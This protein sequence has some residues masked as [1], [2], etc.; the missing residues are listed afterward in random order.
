MHLSEEYSKYLDWTCYYQYMLTI[1]QNSNPKMSTDNPEWHHI[2]QSAFRLHCNMLDQV[3]LIEKHFAQ[4]SQLMSN[5]D[6]IPED[7]PLNYQS[8]QQTFN[9]Q[10]DGTDRQK[11][12]DKTNDIMDAIYPLGRNIR[13]LLKENTSDKNNGYYNVI[14]RNLYG[15]LEIR[16]NNLSLLVNIIENS[17]FLK[18]ATMKSQEQWIKNIEH[19]EKKTFKHKLFDRQM[20]I[21][22]NPDLPPQIRAN[23]E[24]DI[25]LA[26][27]NFFKH[28]CEFDIY[29]IYKDDS[30]QKIY[31]DD[32]TR[33]ALKAFFK[34]CNSFDVSCIYKDDLLPQIH[35]ENPDLHTLIQ[36]AT[37]RVNKCTNFSKLSAL[38]HKRLKDFK[39]DVADHKIIFDDLEGRD[40]IKMTNAILQLEVMR[41]LTD[42]A[43]QK[44]HQ[45]IQNGKS[46]KADHFID[47]LTKC[48]DNMFQVYA[49]INRFATIYGMNVEQLA[50]IKGVPYDP[51]I[52]QTLK[53]YSHNL[54]ILQQKFKLTAIDYTIANNHK[55]NNEVKLQ[56]IKQF[57]QEQQA[58]LIERTHTEL[59][60][61]LPSEAEQ[62]T[63]QLPQPNINLNYST[64]NAVV[65]NN[66][67]NYENNGSNG[68][69]YPSS[70]SVQSYT[71]VAQPVI[72]RNNHQETQQSNLPVPYFY[73]A[74]NTPSRSAQSY[75][76]VA[77]PV[78]FRN[79]HQELQQSSLPAPQFYH[80]NGNP[81]QS[82]QSSYPQQLNMQQPAIYGANY[83]K[84]QQSNLP[85]PYFYNTNNTPSQSA[86]P[87]ANIH[88]NP[89]AQ[90]YC[91]SQNAV[92][93]K[94]KMT[95]MRSHSVT[96][97]VVPHN[98]QADH[99]NYNNSASSTNPY[100]A[101]YF[102]SHASQYSNPTVQTN[103]SQNNVPIR[104]QITNRRSQ[105]AVNP[106]YPVATQ[107]SNIVQQNNQYNYRKI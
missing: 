37:T 94:P 67:Y 8:M 28:Y 56:I 35:T 68:N 14:L 89:T 93:P 27:K 36:E 106:H 69:Y 92:P 53:S 86:Q 41:A 6:E 42:A 7:Y 23:T 63:A 31:I 83:Q 107:Q 45:L 95:Y 88:T 85:V 78:I 12:V 72:F 102:S 32:S 103:A 97:N 44:M 50:K 29:S 80:T 51:D 10:Q 70:R 39:E 9:N 52:T 1:S 19:L 34:N 62:E 76:P 87:N 65:Q 104:P 101:I 90:T 59:A 33:L 48:Y 22:N 98:D 43:E 96:K 24:Q 49:S 21:I 58:K 61:V 16:L 79:N 25:Q 18:S 11:Y 71:P 75:N 81:I 84:P 26:L 5:S 13:K 15:V 82:V 64:V 2:R 54:D 17:D 66:Q 57:P 20:K 100:L 38:M 105:S 73:N 99:R 47:K 55:Y 46:H 74:N 60:D 4:L 30:S 40:P 3:R 91:T 77:Q